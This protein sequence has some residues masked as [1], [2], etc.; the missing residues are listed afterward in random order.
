MQEFKVCKAV[1][2]IFVQSRSIMRATKFFLSL[3]M[4][5]R[6]IVDIL[7]IGVLLIAFSAVVHAS[8]ITIGWDNN[9]EPDI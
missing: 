6:N 3:T 2:S 4:R 8:Q 5:V 9:S 7:A 1:G